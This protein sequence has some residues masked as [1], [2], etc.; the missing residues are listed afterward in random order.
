MTHRIQG[1]LPACLV[2]IVGL[3]WAS[4]LR[5]QYTTGQVR[6]MV[7]D[8]S[9]GLIP[10]A[11]VA[12]TNQETGNQRVFTT[13]EGG[14][15]L[16]VAVPAGTYE[17]SAQAQGFAKMT[18]TLVVHANE[19]L[20][21]DLTLKIA[22]T[23]QV[24]TVSEEAGS[25]PT[26]DVTN[27][28]LGTIRS[29]VE[30]ND[31]PS[32]GRSFSNLI[33]L[34]PGV[35]P[36]FNPRG[37]SLA[38]TSGSQAGSI[39][40]NGG[41]ARETAYQLDYTDANDWEFG[42]LAQGRNLMPD[43]IQEVT[44]LTSNFSAEY[45]V[46]ASSQVL[47]V[48]KSGTNR[49]HG[50]ADDFIQNDIFNARDY[51][52]R[53]G[54]PS[55][56]RYN[57]YSVT[58]GGRIIKNRAFIF[59]GFNGIKVRGA[60]STAIA[61]VPTDAARNRAT[62]PVIVSLMKQFLP[63]PTGTTSNADVGTFTSHFSGPTNDWQFVTKFDYK[64]SDKHYISARYLQSRNAFLLLFPALN[65]LPG[66]DTNFTSEGNDVSLS[67]TYLFKPQTTNQLRF[68]YGRA[69]TSILSQNGLV[70]P[71][72]NIGGLVGFGALQ[73]FPNTRLFNVFQVND[74]LTHVFG[75]H[76]FAMGFDARKIQ[77]N[78]FLATN[79][80]GYFDFPS[81]D[82]FLAGQPDYWTQLFGP[83]YRGYRSGL[84]GFFFQDDWKATPTLTLNLGFR[85]DVQG[86]LSEVN[87]LTSSLY[88]PAQGMIGVA[89]LGPLG[90]LKVGNPAIKAN[91]FNLGPRFG[92]AWNPGGGNLVVRGGYGLYYDSF[93]FTPLTFGRSVPPLNYN[94]SLGGSQISGQN[95]FDSIY[96]GTAPIVVQTVSQVGGFGQLTNFGSIRTLDRYMKNPY[97]QNFSLGIQYRFLQ[98]YLLS[99]AYV[100]AK[101]TRLTQLFPINPVVNGPAPA[102]SLADEAARLSQ[103]QAAEGQENGPGNLRLDPRF[104]EVAYQDSAASSIYHSLQLGLRKNFAREG[105]Q[106][107]FSYTWSK[108]I[109]NASDFTPEQQAND[110]SFAQN[111]FDRNADRAVSNFDIPHRVLGTLIWQIPS[112]KG[113]Q[114]IAGHVLGGWAF[115]SVQM[116]QSGVPATVIAGSRLGIP[117]VNLQGDPVPGVGIDST[118]ASCVPG[119]V[120]FTLNEAS[121]IPAPS[122]RGVNGS[123]NSSNFLYTQP[124]LGNNGTCG[125]NTL[126]MNSL[127][128]FDWSMLKDTKISESGPFGS[129]PW[130]LEFRV[131][132]FNIFNTPFLTAQGNNWRTLSSAGF[133]LLNAGAA[134]R[135]LQVALKLSW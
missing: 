102:T 120:G 48:T 121:T 114:G 13:G 46:K 107:N 96:N 36:T 44:V 68:A 6:G 106:F 34:E 4:N 115:Q 21:Q 42:G 38:I 3:F 94:A 91:P 133:G 129:G 1:L 47:L 15:Y 49:F 99:V 82:A 24:V 29:S 101:G 126:R 17:I 105:L 10:G 45:G 124:L 35:Q 2:I 61:L 85:W 28:Q 7:K 87:N 31:L 123:P 74:V 72:F 84:Y 16:F 18:T 89:G 62:D 27:A 12:L 43:A 117:D 73:F 71:R 32:S 19:T 67:D 83:S 53:S 52:D 79:A 93:D 37:G 104:N 55:L 88:P 81:L 75:L 41:R 118:R 132:A 54:H 112:F 110:M 80:N 70:S 57:N 90:T 14:I 60:G 23:S 30:V 64:L 92:F 26:L 9:G 103:F 119:G 128:N 108:S 86:N 22:G 63:E 39:A 76:T 109:D 25:V 58:A 131:E 51:F 56:I 130:M 5:A 77:D 98:H 111:A 116:W 69:P 20:A 100:G 113:Q 78:T 33:S 134:T 95:N 97:V 65:T 50:T 8:P 66:F 127:T 11:N 59:G 122:T 40:S 125:R 135:H